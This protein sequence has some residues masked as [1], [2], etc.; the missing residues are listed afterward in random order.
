MNPWQ[1]TPT[2]ISILLISRLSGWAMHAY[3]QGCRW[4]DARALRVR[5]VIDIDEVDSH[6]MLTAASVRRRGW[7]P[8]LMKA[9]LGSP[10]YAVVDPL[11]RNEPY[12]LFSRRRVERAEQSEALLRYLSLQTAQTRISNVRIRKWIALRHPVTS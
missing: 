12:I 11:G 9:V 6:S 1:I 4:L 2:T 3:R 8:E 5:R 7:S 10:D